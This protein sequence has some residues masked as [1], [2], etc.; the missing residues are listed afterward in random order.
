[1]II[2]KQ[3]KYELE[4]LKQFCDLICDNGSWRRI[5]GQLMWCVQE[6]ASDEAFKLLEE[7]DA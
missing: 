5:E 4:V 3:E 7:I 1:M 2:N 6:E